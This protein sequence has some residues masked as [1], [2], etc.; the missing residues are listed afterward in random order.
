[1]SGSNAFGSEGACVGTIL[2]EEGLR[3]SDLGLRADDFSDAFLRRVF[4]DCISLEAAGKTADLVNVCDIDPSLDAAWLVEL[5][6]QAGP[7]VSRAEEYAANV[8]TASQRRQTVQLCQRTMQ[9]ALDAAQSLEETV[10]SARAGLEGIL[11]GSPGT[12]SVGGTDALVD[13]YES[14]TSGKTPPALS[15]G[16]PRLDKRLNG[17]LRGGQLIVIGARPGV[18]KSA[19]MSF[20]AV[21][22][23]IQAGKRVL[24]VSLEMSE[25][26]VVTRMITL[27][28]GVSAGSMVSGAVDEVRLG[29]LV[30]SFSLLPGALFRITTRAVTPETVRREALRMR[31]DGGLDL[32]V[33]DYLQL[34]RTDARVNGRV[35]AVGEISRAL[36]L[37]ALELDVPVLVGAQVNRASTIGVERAPRI[38]ELRESGSIEQDADVVIMMHAP[39]NDKTLRELRLEK[40]RQGRTGVTDVLFDGSRM[41][42]TEAEEG[43]YEQGF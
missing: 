30:E 22:G 37:L 13:L 33:V 32:I 35:E 34:M 17:G 38:S 10:S 31:A 18:G 8:R 2:C 1:M 11:A 23:A 20:V 27:V 25:R 29:R 9:A 7:S 3:A 36:K 6:Q 12:G 15:T 16:F 40:H 26:E 41:L 5:T 19:L 14:L 21:R 43:T 4:A 39:D 24:I 28:S 42:F